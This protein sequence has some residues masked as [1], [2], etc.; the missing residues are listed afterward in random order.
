MFHSL[1]NLY[2]NTNK[3]KMIE[4]LAQTHNVPLANMEQIYM[5]TTNAIEK[6][7]NPTKTR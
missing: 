3:I 6:I 4:M 7:K 5:Q 1:L 2:R